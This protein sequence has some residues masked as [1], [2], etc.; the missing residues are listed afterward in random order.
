[1]AV[2]ELVRWRGTILSIS[3]E[4]VEGVRLGTLLD[5]GVELAEGVRPENFW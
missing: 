4:L 2:R 5:V 3:V 1:M